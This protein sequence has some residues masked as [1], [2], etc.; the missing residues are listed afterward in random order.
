MRT[1][2]DLRLLHG[3]ASLYVQPSLCEGFGLPPVEAM[4]CG[5]P[6]LSSDAGSLAE[7]LGDAARLL[8]PT[9]HAAAW[10]EAVNE[11][12]ADD[13]GRPARVARGIAKAASY[14]WEQTA[15]LTRQAYVRAMGSL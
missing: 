8:P 13:S 15:A 1:D 7:V 5:T 11:L 14:R 9:G 2:A 12:L 10:A 6:V 4:A 3:A